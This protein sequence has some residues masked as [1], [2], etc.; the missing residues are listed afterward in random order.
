MSDFLPDWNQQKTGFE[1][2]AGPQLQTSGEREP[3]P[4]DEHVRQVVL[5]DLRHQGPIYQEIVRMMQRG[6]PVRSQLETPPYG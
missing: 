1:S 2:P 6:W 5:H 4:S 3:R